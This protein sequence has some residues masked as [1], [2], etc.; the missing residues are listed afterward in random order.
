MRNIIRTFFWSFGI[1]PFVA[2]GSAIQHCYKDCEFT[3]CPEVNLALLTTRN[4]ANCH[5]ASF[6][7]ARGFVTKFCCKSVWPNESQ[8]L[9]QACGAHNTAYIIPYNCSVAAVVKAS[10]SCRKLL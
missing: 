9:C 1:N 3:F 5:S 10:M 6:K 8:F 7:L 2:E 4:I